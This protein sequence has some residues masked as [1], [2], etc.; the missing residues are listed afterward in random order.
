MKRFVVAGFLL[1]MLLSFSGCETTKPPAVTEAMAR[2]G[3]SQERLTEGRALF[4][5]R[6]I[7]CHSLPPITK[8][9]AEEWPGLVGKMSGR[10]HLSA[11]QKE[12]VIAYILAARS[13]SH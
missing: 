8:Y 5:S 13:T 1:S 4:V 6:C 3:A 9:S 7:D 12:S 11:D 2:G 10:A